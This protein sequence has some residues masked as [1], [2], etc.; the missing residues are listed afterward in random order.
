MHLQNITFHRWS[1]GKQTFIKKNQLTEEE[2][3]QEINNYPEWDYQ[4]SSKI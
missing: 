3:Q 4:V 2:I 1:Y